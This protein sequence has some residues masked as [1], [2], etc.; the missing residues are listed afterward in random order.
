[1]LVNPYFSR[2]PSWFQF[3]LKFGITSNNFDKTFSL[4]FVLIF[5]WFLVSILKKNQF[6][7]KRKQHIRTPNLIACEHKK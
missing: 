3:F 1:M 6:W 2:E 4:V 7:V 5:G